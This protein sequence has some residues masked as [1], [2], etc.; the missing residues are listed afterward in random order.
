MSLAIYIKAPQIAVIYI[1]DT[2]F[3]LLQGN[4]GKKVYFPMSDETSTLVLNCITEAVI[5]S[6]VIT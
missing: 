6:V 1:N 4:E 3:T 2:T 5:I